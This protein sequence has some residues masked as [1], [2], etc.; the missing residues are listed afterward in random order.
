[1]LYLE[2]ERESV[3]VCVVC[4]YCVRITHPKILK[5]ETL[6][7]KTHFNPPIGLSH[8][9]LPDKVSLYSSAHQYQISI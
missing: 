6:K 5:K 4:V 9:L 8:A 1:M 3:C 2:R 7:K